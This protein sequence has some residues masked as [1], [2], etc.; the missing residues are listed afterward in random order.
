MCQLTRQL[1]CFLPVS[2]LASFARQTADIAKIVDMIASIADPIRKESVE[3][4]S[5]FVIE[6]LLSYAV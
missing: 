6:C 4:L 1:F 3:T 5:F 2:F